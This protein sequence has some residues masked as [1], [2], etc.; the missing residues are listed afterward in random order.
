MLE[1]VLPKA[2][3]RRL[4]LRETQGQ[5]KLPNDFTDCTT[6]CLAFRMTKDLRHTG[7][8]VMNCEVT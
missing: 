1:L 3:T 2:I 5:Q 7:R 6:A 8:C 4:G